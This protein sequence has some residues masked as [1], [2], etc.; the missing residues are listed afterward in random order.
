MSKN[1]DLSELINYVKGTSTGQ[2]IAPSYTSASSFTGTIAGYLGFDSSG[3]I[4]TTGSASQWITSGS[5]IYYNTGNVGIGV[6][7]SAWISGYKA[8]EMPQFSVFSGAGGG[9]FILGNAYLNNSGD[10]IYKVTGQAA[11]AYNNQGG[12]HIFSVTS[13]NGT[14]GNIISFVEAL[15]ITSAGRVGIGLSSPS[16]KLAVLSAP[17]AGGFDGVSVTTGTNDVISLFRTGSSYSYGMVGVNQSWM[18]SNFGDLN[19]MTDASGASIKFGTSGGAERMRITSNGSVGIGTT[20]PIGDSPSHVSLTITNGS[21]MTLAL[22]SSAT[23]VSSY[24]QTTGQGLLIYNGSDTG[25]ISVTA[26]TQ[27]VYLAPN[28]TSWSS[29]SDENLKTDLSPIENGLEK[30]ISLR[31][32]TGKYKKDANGIS[33]SFLIAQ[34]VQSVLPEAVTINAN[35]GYLNLSYTDVIP[36]LVASIKEL[37][38][39]LDELKGNNQ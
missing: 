9:G 38:S 26:K 39:E 14:A 7:P 17:S 22:R 13:T 4:L 3:N 31:A 29:L 12:S 27:G 18:Y 32:L 10:F 30:I 1:T 36:L 33:R 25:G 24:L 15:R 8:I 28:G 21:T 19:I 11:S 6:N 16:Y 2:L 37:K 35:D 5:N 20:T 34:D 23:L